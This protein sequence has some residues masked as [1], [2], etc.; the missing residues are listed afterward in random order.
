[1]R[2]YYACCYTMGLFTGFTGVANAIPYFYAYYLIK[3]NII[4]IH[5]GEKEKNATYCNF[6]FNVTGRRRRIHCGYEYVEPR[7]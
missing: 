1:M 6:A 3:F 5:K 2:L 4:Y 7:T